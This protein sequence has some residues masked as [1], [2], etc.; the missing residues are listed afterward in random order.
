VARYNFITP[1]LCNDMHGQFGCPTFDLVKPGD[2]WLHANL[3]AL[4]TFCEAN[5]GVVFVVWDEGEG[6]P[7][8]PFLAVG[9][10]VK[11]NYSSGVKYTHGSLVK[12][13]EELFG[14]PILATVANENDFGDLFLPG[15]FP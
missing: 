15:A 12:S 3:P 4:I 6:S 9:P 1:N 5:D 13:V 14:L 7:I 10:S 8:I 11:S 2:D